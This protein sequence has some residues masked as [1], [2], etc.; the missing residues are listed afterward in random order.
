MNSVRGL[1]YLEMLTVSNQDYDAVTKTFI[2]YISC[3]LL[4][5]RYLDLSG[6]VWVI[7]SNLESI[8]NLPKLQVVKINEL[9]VITGSGLGNFPNLKEF[10]CKSCDN[11]EDEHL[12]RLLRCSDKLEYLDITG[13]D[14]ITNSVVNVAIEV[15]KNRKN[16]IAMEMFTFGTA[17]NLD[18]VD[19]G[20]TLL[21]LFY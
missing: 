16:N 5:L 10:H 4:D 2:D 14:K 17:T 9:K 13:C 21:Y 19:G 7:D 3:N 11:L 6:C 8:C 15:T 20:S 1:K 12:I 18:E